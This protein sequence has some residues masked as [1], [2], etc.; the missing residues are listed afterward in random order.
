MVVMA[1][2]FALYVVRGAAAG[3]PPDYYVVGPG[4]TVWSIAVTHYPPQEDP[5]PKVAEI[6]DA[7]GLTGYRIHPGQRLELPPVD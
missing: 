5:R 3:P 6:R 4:D 1:L 2:A 7:N